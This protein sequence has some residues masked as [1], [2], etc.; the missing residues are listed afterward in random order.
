MKQSL[1][2]LPPS[3]SLTAVGVLGSWGLPALDAS[4]QAGLL[5]PAPLS[6]RCVEVTC[7]AA[8]LALPSLIFEEASVVRKYSLFPSSV[9]GRVGC[10]CLLAVTNSAAV[11]RCVRVCLNTFQVCTSE[12][13]C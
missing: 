6:H 11:S 9:G 7:A 13:N 1:L 2:A 3:H 8:V 4:D 5:H 12:W 10:F